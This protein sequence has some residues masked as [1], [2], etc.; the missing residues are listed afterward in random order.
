MIV[1]QLQ[2]AETTLQSWNSTAA[3]SLLERY[4]RSWCIPLYS[5]WSGNIFDIANMEK[6]FDR[7]SLNQIMINFYDS[8]GPIGYQMAHNIQMAVLSSMERA[9]RLRNETIC[10][11]GAHSSARRAANGLAFGCH[12]RPIKYV[13][14]ILS[15]LQ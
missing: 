10:R 5:S 4:Q 2:L 7:T 8:N 13:Q 14:N 9:F 15:N 11:A 1:P 6:P 3:A 12:G